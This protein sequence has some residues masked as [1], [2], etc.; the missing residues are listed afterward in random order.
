MVDV[1]EHR[2][3]A[4]D[5]RAPIG[6]LNRLWKRNWNACDSSIW[7]PCRRRRHTVTGG[8]RVPILPRF[9]AKPLLIWE[10]CQCLVVHTTQVWVLSTVFNRFQTQRIKRVISLLFINLAHPPAY[11]ENLHDLWNSELRVLR[12][13]DLE[14]LQAMPPSALQSSTGPADPR[15]L[16]DCLLRNHHHSGSAAPE[17]KAASASGPVRAQPQQRGTY[18]AAAVLLSN[19]RISL[20]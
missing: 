18:W 5:T 20:R 14:A 8:T 12:Y 10:G 6:T 13:R 2:N 11:S 16:I 17:H 15:F 9:A 3:R 1:Q 19:I 4:F 7:S